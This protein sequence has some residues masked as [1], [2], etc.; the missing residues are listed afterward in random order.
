M[1]SPSFGTV[2]NLCRALD[3][4]LDTAAHEWGG[5]VDEARVS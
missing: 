5:L 2:V 3:L 4:P 1:P